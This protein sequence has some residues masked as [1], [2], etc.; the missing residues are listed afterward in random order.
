LGAALLA[1]LMLA[2]AQLLARRTAEDLER[3]L[4]AIGSAATTLA[5]GRMSGPIALAARAPGEL[6]TLAA[7]LE[8]L[9]QRLEG[10]PSA[11]PAPM[12]ESAAD[13]GQLATLGESSEFDLALLMQQLVE[14]ARKMAHTRGIE[15]QLVFPDGLPSQLQGHPM[16]LFRALDSLLR[17]ALRVTRQG[18]ITLRVSR[19]GGPGSEGKL[20]FEL[21]DTS[22]GIA[23]KDQPELSAR[24][25]AAAEADPN[26]LQDPLELASALARALGGELSFVS[27]PAQGSRFGFTVAFS[28]LPVSAA[29][30]FYPAAAVLPT[31]ALQGPARG[32]ESIGPAISSFAPRPALR[33][34]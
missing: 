1:G 23:F 22:E 33:R 16:A 4:A 29:T 27:Q 11:Q 21:A 9:R 18:R 30:G 6:A 13:A 25:A 14:P 8:T 31:P 7:A 10:G 34:R 28:G 19:A 12:A 26:T 20:R 24:L 32:N 15:V 2:C 5:E 17:H 3:N